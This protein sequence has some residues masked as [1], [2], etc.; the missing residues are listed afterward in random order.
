MSTL[1]KEGA[2]LKNNLQKSDALNFFELQTL[3]TAHTIRQKKVV[4][5]VKKTSI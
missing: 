5:L 2:P 3:R 4:N 1:S